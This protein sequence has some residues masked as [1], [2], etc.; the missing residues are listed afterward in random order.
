MPKF[1]WQ[2]GQ[3]LPL[4]GCILLLIALVV[5]LIVLCEFTGGSGGQALVTA[6]GVG[7]GTGAAQRGDRSGEHSLI[8][9]QSIGGHAGKWPGPR[10]LQA[11]WRQLS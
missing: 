6:G 9:C 4:I 5:S 2:E 7:S 3:K 8:G 10:H 1:T 11:L